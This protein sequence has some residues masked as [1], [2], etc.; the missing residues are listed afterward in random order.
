VMIDQLSFMYVSPN[1]SVG[2]LIPMVDNSQP[3]TENIDVGMYSSLMGTFN[4]MALVHH[5]YAMSS[6]SASSMRFVPFR[7]LYFNDPWTL[8]S[9]TA[10]CEGQSHT[11]MA[12]PLS[13]TKISYQVVLDSFIDLDLV[14]S[15]TDEE[16]PVLE[17]LWATTVS[18]SH[19]CVDDT[20]T[21]NEDIIE[22]MG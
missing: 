4:F 19:D 15:Q 22:A 10:S 13:K 12:M 5:I 21:S 9:S 11:R 2:T 7:T 17:P 18:C 20:L 6:R 3:K 1:A 14:T 16:D 8:P